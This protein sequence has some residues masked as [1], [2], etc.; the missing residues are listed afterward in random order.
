MSLLNMKL[1]DLHKQLEEQ[2][3]KPSDLTEASL[4]RVKET[5]DHINAFITL[6]EQAMAQ[7][8]ILDEESVQKDGRSPIYALP[9]A[10][11]DSVMTEGLRTTGGSRMLHDHQAVYQATVSAKLQ[12]AHAVIIGKTN[13]DELGM[14]SSSE[15]TLQAPVRNPWDI[16]HVAGGSSGG[17]AAAVAARQVYYAIG[18]DTGGGIRQP[19]AYC[20][21]VGLKP[22]Y[23][24]VSRFGLIAAASS[25]DH[26]GCITKD[27]TDAAF[28][29]QEIAGYDPLDSTS[30]DGVI[31]R[32][33]DELNGDI[34]GL[35]IG[36]VKQF[37]TDDVDPKIRA[38]ITEAVELFEQLGAECTEVSLPHLDYGLPTYMT[39]AAAEASS[40]LA[41]LD[42]VRYGERVQA[43]DLLALYEQSRAAG[44]N[45]E[46]KRRML[47]GAYVLSE[48]HYEDYYVQAQKVRTLIK[49]ELTQALTQYDV[50]IGP[51]TPTTA[52]KIGE[53]Q[54][55]PLAMA[56]NDRLTVPANL[57]GIPSISVPCGMAE[58]LPIGMQIIGPAYGEQTLLRL[59]HAFEHHTTHHKAM[60][61]C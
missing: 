33:A 22:T 4:K 42:G 8:L 59:A 32:Y 25:L 34:K 52:F 26:L 16:D 46:A 24:L 56:A 57:A 18:S 36:I 7:A 15:Y 60:P 43:S 17:S 14:G 45:D 9:V 13:M 19:A 61:P 5:D 54:D 6:N 20:G 10:L 27:V 49:Q 47:L 41:R 21:V 23:G 40:N 3:I 51:T 55:D 28:V 2:Q 35:R 29:L 12:A 48:G 50:L 58:G 37:M 30:Y 31:P 39:I 44:F 1:Q 38:A 11:K 53:K